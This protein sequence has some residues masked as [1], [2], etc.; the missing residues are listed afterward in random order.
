MNST[1][2]S[3]VKRDI[4]GGSVVCVAGKIYIIYGQMQE[5]KPHRERGGLSKRLAVACLLALARVPS[6]LPFIQDS[7]AIQKKADY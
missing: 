4:D 6:H 3:K 5:R 1:S 7:H 2:N